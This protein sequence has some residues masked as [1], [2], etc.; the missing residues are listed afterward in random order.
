VF[1]Y[2]SGFTFPVTVLL[3]L[4]FSLGI[5]VADYHGAYLARRAPALSTVATTLVA[6]LAVMVGLA[7]LIP[8][9]LVAQD[10]V[11]GVGSGSMIGFGLASMYRGIS[12]S[13]AAVVAPISAFLAAVVPFSWDLATGGTLS[14]VAVA[15][16]VVALVGL[17]ASTISPELGSQVRVGVRWGLAG[18]GFFGAAMT[19]LGETSQSSG[20]WPAVAQRMTALGALLLA[21]QL[22][23]VAPLVSRGLRSRAA[24][25]G[26][27]GASAIAAFTVGAQR[28]SL[29][30]MAIVTALA[31]AV[32]AIMSAVFDGHPMRWWQVLGAFT[33]A[34]GVGL[35]G[36]G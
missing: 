7:L 8:G 31:P 12:E 17:V 6:G 22:R 27:L 35:L 1:G 33:A 5:G 19:L 29:A 4:W 24:L 14:G 10:V 18:G 15:G 20:L 25:S 21:A 2:P 13:S 16:S 30:E 23:G 28:G 36:L 32:T 34:V 9:G 26:V 3:G 11:L